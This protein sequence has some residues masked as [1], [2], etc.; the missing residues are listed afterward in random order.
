MAAF[1]WNSF[2]GAGGSGANLLNTGGQLGLTAL[3]NRGKEIQGEYSV[4]LQKLLNNA[5]K[6]KAE[7]DVELA[8]LN[9][10]RDQALGAVETSKARLY[11][12]YGLAGLVVL[13]IVVGIVLL[14]RRS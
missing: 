5:T 11:L 8:K 1:N 14:V 10:S 12:G 9:A 7:V 4:E 6:T 13:G 2:L 3:Q